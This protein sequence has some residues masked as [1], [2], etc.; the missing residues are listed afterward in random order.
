MTHEYE[1][2]GM[3]RNVS[4]RNGNTRIKAV[5]FFFFLGDRSSKFERKWKYILL[6][7]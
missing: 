3:L 2:G 4:V 6:L 1:Q 5:F 7:F